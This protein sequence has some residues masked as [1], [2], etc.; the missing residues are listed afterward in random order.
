[1]VDATNRVISGLAAPPPR[2][3][4]ES[5]EELTGRLSTEG[6]MSRKSMYESTAVERNLVLA[7]RRAHSKST[8]VRDGKSTVVRE[9][10]QIHLDYWAAVNRIR[11]G[12]RHQERPVIE[13]FARET[14]PSCDPQD[15]FRRAGSGDGLSGHEIADLDAHGEHRDQLVAI[16]CRLLRGMLDEAGFGRVEIAESSLIGIKLSDIKV[17]TLDARQLAVYGICL[18]VAVATEAVFADSTFRHSTLCIRAQPDAR[19]DFSW[20]DLATNGTQRQYELLALAEEE[21]V[22]VKTDDDA[23]A[24]HFV[25]CVLPKVN[26]QRAFLQGVMFAR[27]ELPAAN[28]DGA[29]LTKATFADCDLTGARFGHHPGTARKTDPKSAVLEGTGFTRCTLAG[30]DRSEATGVPLG[31]D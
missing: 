1:M 2:S 17:G 30:A 14:L 31:W 22:D 18:D 9:E 24:V 11:A 12:T 23:G 4:I 13:D 15:F 8:V 7:G 6:L 29:D 16:N 19:I 20:T 25:D 27:C 5:S 26:F 3:V 10:L 28:F 21:Q